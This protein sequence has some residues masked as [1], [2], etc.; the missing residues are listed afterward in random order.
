MS[1]QLL[2]NNYEGY[3]V[4]YLTVHGCVLCSDCATKEWS[5]KELGMME[6]DEPCVHWE[7]EPVTCDDCSKEIESAY[8]P[9][10]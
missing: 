7:G 8:G 6:T 4:F 10:E 2:P 1:E 5:D 3:P 9:V